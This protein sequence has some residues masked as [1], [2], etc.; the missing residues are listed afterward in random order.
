MRSQ[1]PSG[2]SV[3]GRFF[4]PTDAAYFPDRWVDCCRKEVASVVNEATWT[5]RNYSVGASLIEHCGLSFG[6][7]SKDEEEAAR[8][9]PSNLMTFFRDRCVVS[10]PYPRVSALLNFRRSAG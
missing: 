3:L 6:H 7:L 1:R 5:T 8:R 10:C 2:L 9:F 4:A